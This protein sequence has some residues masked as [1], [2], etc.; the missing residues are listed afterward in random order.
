MT[1]GAAQHRTSAEA[2]GPPIGV[3]FRE[4]SSA[5]NAK[6]GSEQ[7]LWAMHRS[8]VKLMRSNSGISIH[9]AQLMLMNG[10]KP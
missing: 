7:L 5:E 1:L 2:N 10:V 4:W 8:F 3:S 6:R 9:D